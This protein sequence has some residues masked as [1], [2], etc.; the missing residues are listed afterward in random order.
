MKKVLAIL[1]IIALSVIP[2]AEASSIS[3]GTEVPFTM[4]QQT[5]DNGDGSA[6]Y[7]IYFRFSNSLWSKISDC[8]YTR[9]NLATVLTPARG[10]Y[11]LATPTQANEILFEAYIPYTDEVSDGTSANVQKTFFTEEFAQIQSVIGDYESVSGSVANLFKHRLPKLESD[12]TNGMEC[13]YVYST[14]KRSV[15]SNAFNVIEDGDVC[16]HVFRLKGLASIEIRSSTPNP[17]GWL[18]VGL[19]ISL[20]IVGAGTLLALYKE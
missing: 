9:D 18:T 20:V 4:T 8:G 12:A 19:I 1:F 2:V 13:Y 14:P 6:T 5:V 17:V 11:R 3:A 16:H 15:T 7:R 10:E